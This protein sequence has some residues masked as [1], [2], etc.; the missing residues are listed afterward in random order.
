MNVGKTLCA[1]VMEFVPW[2][3]YSRIVERH[4]G[5]AGVRLRN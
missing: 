5:N 2:T 4:G 3:S 1:Q